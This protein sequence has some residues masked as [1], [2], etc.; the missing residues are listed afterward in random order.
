MAHLEQVLKTV[1]DDRT[2][3]KN[4]TRLRDGGCNALTSLHPHDDYCMLDNP[5][6]E[7]FTVQLNVQR[8][9]RR[10]SKEEKRKEKGRAISDAR[11]RGRDGYWFRWQRDPTNTNRV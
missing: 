9:P 6:G 5:E 10:W 11:Q 2:I 1:N 8:H 4:G 7:P 3:C